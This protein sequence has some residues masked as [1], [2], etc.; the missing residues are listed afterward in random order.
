[1]QR[2]GEVLCRLHAF[3]QGILAQM[4]EYFFHNARSL[5]DLTVSGITPHFPSI[6]WIVTHCGCVLPQ[7]IHHLV[8]FADGYL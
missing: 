3:G 5:N 6:S 8:L 4:F 2:R 7:L 1:M